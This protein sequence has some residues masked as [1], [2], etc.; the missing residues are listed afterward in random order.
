LGKRLTFWGQP[1]I[2]KAMVTME[3][4]YSCS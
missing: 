3:P 4:K 2:H 1:V